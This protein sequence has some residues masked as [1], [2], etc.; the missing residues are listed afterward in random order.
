MGNLIA[1]VSYLKA[2][3]N[4]HSIW[5]A[6]LKYQKIYL[7]LRIDDLL[8]SQKT[9]LAFIEGMGITPPVREPSET[10]SPIRKFKR[11]VNLLV[12]VYRMM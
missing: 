4:R 7:T 11:C 10:I 6:D 5:R 3:L 9:T 8:S 2:V 12:G 1:E